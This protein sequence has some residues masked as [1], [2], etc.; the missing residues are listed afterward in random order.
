MERHYHFHLLPEDNDWL[1]MVILIIVIG[2]VII[3]FLT[4]A[5]SNTQTPKTEQTSIIQ[6]NNSTDYVK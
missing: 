2:N 5:K 4:V 3:G 6:T 1:V